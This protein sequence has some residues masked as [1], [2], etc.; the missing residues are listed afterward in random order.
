[1]TKFKLMLGT[2]GEDANNSK[3]RGQMIRTLP[4]KSTWKKGD[5]DLVQ[6][7]WNDGEIFSSGPCSEQCDARIG[8][9]I[10]VELCELAQ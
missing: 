5:P 10:E 1:M 9:F 6:V 2:F 8:D 4:R 3:L 7:I